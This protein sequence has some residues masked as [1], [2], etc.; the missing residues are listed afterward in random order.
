MAGETRLVEI[1]AFLVTLVLS[2]TTLVGGATDL[3]QLTEE[4]LPSQDG[5]YLDSLNDVALSAGYV[6]FDADFYR[7]FAFV[8]PF[9]WEAI[10]H[11][12]S[13]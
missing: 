4:L 13:F 1:Q 7:T 5:Y 2:F 12:T 11:D 3:E 8:C 9:S 10:F 6:P